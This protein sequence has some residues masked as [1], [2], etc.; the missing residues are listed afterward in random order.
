[1]KKSATTKEHFF[2]RNELIVALLGI[3]LSFFIT[4][5]C[6]WIPLA[7]SADVTACE[8]E[9]INYISDPSG[10]VFKTDEYTL[11]INNSTYKI[12]SNKNTATCTAVFDDVANTYNYYG[13]AHLFIGILYDITVT[14]VI[15]ISFELGFMIFF[16]II[17]D[18][19]YL[20]YFKKLN[21]EYIL[22]KAEAELKISSE[23]AKTYEN[24]LML[25]EAYDE[26]QEN[27]Y[28]DGYSQ[29]RKQGYKRGQVDAYD[30]GYVKGFA[31]GQDELFASIHT[32]LN[33]QNDDKISEDT[34]L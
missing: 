2:T 26:A 11:E 23:D 13:N 19:V 28:N 24:S 5:S 29:G 30:E 21:H 32:F 25:K 20:K 1:M 4:V 6:F 16:G 22:K 7:T 34:N 3:V 9:L 33:S 8:Q 14:I 31:E 12:S 17:H 10:Y 18:F 27:G 15:T